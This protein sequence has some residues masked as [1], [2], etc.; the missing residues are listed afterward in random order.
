DEFARLGHDQV[1]LQ[2]LRLPCGQVLE[3]YR[4]MIDWVDVGQRSRI[5]CLVLP[6]LKVHDLRSADAE[7]DSKHFQTGYLLRQGR[8]KAGPTLLN[9]T[10]VKSRG[11]SDCLDMVTG[12]VW[13]AQFIIVSRNCRVLSTM[14]TRDGVGEGRT[15]IGVANAA[16]ARPPAGIHREL[17]KVRKPSSLGDER[18]LTGRQILEFAQVDLLFP[19]GLQIGIEESCVTYLIIG[20][21]GDI[22][23]L[24]AIKNNQA[25]LI[26]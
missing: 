20:V 23:G 13:I 25:S 22:L 2:R 12:I 8:V 17:L 19:F 18:D 14:Q 24:I 9:K 7:E 16:V 4:R 15:E 26:A 21:V 11:E 10:K 6:G 1:G 3:C 5:T